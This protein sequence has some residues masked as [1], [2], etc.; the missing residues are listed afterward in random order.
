MI[1]RT[2]GEKPPTNL[3]R[4][5]LPVEELPNTQNL[6]MKR[7]TEHHEDCGEIK[8]NHKSAEGIELSIS[9]QNFGTPPEVGDSLMF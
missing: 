1:F 3:C 6:T 8:E 4:G 7:K 5:Y 2:T 9:L